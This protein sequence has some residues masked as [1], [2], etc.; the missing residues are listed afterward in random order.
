VPG[1]SSKLALA[2]DLAA[3]DVAT[4][5]PGSAPA[6]ANEVWIATTGPTHVA[7][8]SAAAARTATS[9]AVIASR[10]STSSQPIV[11][12]AITA[13]WLAAAAA[14]LL[15][16][17][18]LGAFFTDDFRR[19]RSDISV[20]R[21]LGFSPREQAAT[22]AAEQFVTVVLAVLVGTVAGAGA[23]ALTVGPFIASAAP[24]STAFVTVV[25]SFDPVPWLLFCAAL[26]IVASAVCLALLVP[27][28]RAAADAVEG[29]AS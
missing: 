8:V 16:L 29:S 27:L 9:T 21:A 12:A 28:R 7:G 4:L 26:T 19:R 15:A 23:T 10:E 13:F 3:L 1:S 5:R 17:V 22:R 20:L 14:A 24:D 18:A 25:P 6:E 11:A 2:T